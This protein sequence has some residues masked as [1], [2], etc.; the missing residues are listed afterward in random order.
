MKSL[1]EKFKEVIANTPH[2]VLQQQWNEI[3]AMGLG[4]PLAKDYIRSF[5]YTPAVQKIDTHKQFS[6]KLIEGLLQH[7]DN[8]DSNLAMAA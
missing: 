7:N 1:L 4:G 3:E 5:R 8:G 6:S 2:E